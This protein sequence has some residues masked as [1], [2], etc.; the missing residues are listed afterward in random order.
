MTKKS[1]DQDVQQIAEFVAGV[2]TETGA[3]SSGAAERPTPEYAAFANA[4]M[5]RVLDY[6]DTLHS[7]T[8][9]QPSNLLP[10]PLSAAELSGAD[11]SELV[12][13]FVGYE[14]SA[15]L[16]TTVCLLDNGALRGV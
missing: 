13:A 11:G 14:V 4:V 15:E 3:S 1:V 5:V 16:A 2:R 6:N 7:A 9:G 8:S 12:A 10:A